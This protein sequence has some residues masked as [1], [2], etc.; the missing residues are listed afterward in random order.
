MTTRALR[1]EVSLK[2]VYTS[3]SAF[4]TKIGL[5]KDDPAKEFLAY[6]RVV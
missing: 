6:E 1:K 2:R 3:A 5:Q 4:P